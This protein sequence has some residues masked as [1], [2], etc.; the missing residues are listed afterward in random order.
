MAAALAAGCAHAPAEPVAA[1]VAPAG[2]LKNADFEAVASSG[3]HCPP[4]WGCSA[5][6]NP[7]SYTF[8]L[9][10]EDRARGRYLQVTRVK[11]EPWALALQ[12]L[13]RPDLAGSRVRLSALVNGEFLDGKA[14]VLIHVRGPS[15]TLLDR[16]KALLGRAPGWRRLSVEIDVAAG[17]ERVEFGLVVEGGGRAGFDD[18]EA[19]VLPPAGA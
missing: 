11:P 14:G 13:H 1:R 18:V 7:H 12:W 3:A 6:S 4:S 5:H 9:S 16:R 2:L 17:V 8:E 19:L 15:G 10:S